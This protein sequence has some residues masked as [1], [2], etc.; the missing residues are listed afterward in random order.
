MKFLKE[1]C[2]FQPFYFTLE[3]LLSETG[4]LNMWITSYRP[5]ISFKRIK[6]EYFNIPKDKLSEIHE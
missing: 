5:L 4:E 1:E 6:F 2:L 3:N